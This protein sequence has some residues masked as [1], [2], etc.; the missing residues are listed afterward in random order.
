M[1]ARG[2]RAAWS[3]AILNIA[4]AA[5]VGAGAAGRDARDAPGSAPFDL[6][7]EHGRVID[8]TG[9]PWYAADIGIRGG[10][11]AAIG[12]LDQATAKRRIDAARSRSWR[13]ASSICSGSRNSRILV[14]PHVPSKIFQGITT[15]ITGEGD[16]VAPVNEAI[17]RAGSA[18]LRALRHQ[19]GLADFR[20]AISRVWNEQGWASISPPTWAPPRC[21]RW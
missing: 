2:W 6:I 7:I 12:R 14:D 19:A 11:I 9:A 18:R 16:S 3:L 15:E 10:R 8:G 4:L 21:A 13:P 5:G 1:A 20:A 17:A